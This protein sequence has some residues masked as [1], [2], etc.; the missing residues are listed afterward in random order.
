MDIQEEK[1]IGKNL[2]FAFENPDFAVRLTA[3]QHRGKG[4]PVRTPGR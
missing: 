3:L 4:P 1:K 2:K